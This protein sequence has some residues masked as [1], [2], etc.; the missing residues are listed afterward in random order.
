[1]P[2]TG[3][4]TLHELSDLIFATLLTQALLYPFH[5][6]NPGL[7]KEI[8]YSFATSKWE[9]VRVSLPGSRPLPSYLSN[10]YICLFIWLILTLEQNKF[11]AVVYEKMEKLY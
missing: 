3:L 8:D 5:K 2:H 9:N 10:K 4:Q 7:E 11:K 6:K 1:M